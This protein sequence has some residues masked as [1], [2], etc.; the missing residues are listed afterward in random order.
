MNKILFILLSSS[1]F[2]FIGYNSIGDKN[3]YFEGEV[4]YEINYNPTDENV[5]PERI[6]ELVGSKMILTYKEGNQ[7][8]QYF[9]P[10][11]KLLTERF[12]NIKNKKSYSRRHDSDTI[13]WI[14]ITKNDTKTTIEM[15]KDEIVSDHPCTV[16]K[17]NSVVTGP[18]FNGKTFES[19]GLYKYA[20]DLPVNP[21][22]YKDYKEGNFNETIK[23]GKG[24][25]VEEFN[26][27]KYWEQHLKVVKVT[28]RKVK[29]R[30]FKIELNGA[31]LKQI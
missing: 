17:T 20:K 6:Q 27:H 8:K 21:E 12:L 11:G 2:S 10:N 24:I 31:P 5:D 23:V 19:T 29:N 28:E 18:G 14:D 25:V 22:W 15:V 26:K 13:V 7:K 1:L 16:I 3:K 30:E 9:A 4:T